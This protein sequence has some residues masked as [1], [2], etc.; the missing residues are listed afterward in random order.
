MSQMYPEDYNMGWQRLHFIKG[1]LFN[2]HKGSNK[3]CLYIAVTHGFFVENYSALAGGTQG[4]VQ[5][6]GIAGV[7]QIGTKTEL[8][9]DRFQDHLKA[10]P[11][12]I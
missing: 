9:A 8:I 2:K 11:N 5:Y 12:L 1:Q 3:K 6:C 4:H 10:V 7:G